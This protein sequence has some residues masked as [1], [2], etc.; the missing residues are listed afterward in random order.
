[1]CGTDVKLFSGAIPVALPRVL[2]HEI[3]GTVAV[4]GPRG[5]VAEGTRVLVDPSIA[6]GYCDLCRRD[7]S[8]LCRNGALMGRDLDG[9]FAELVAVDERQLHPIPETVSDDAAA[10]LQVLTTCVHA[11]TLVDVFPGMTAVVLGL[12]VSGQLH[13]QLLRARGLS[14]VI[15]VTRSEARRALAAELGATDVAA[16]EDAAALVA[17]RTG[18]RGADLVVESAGVAATLAQAVELAGLGG[19]VLAFGTI[20]A[21]TLPLP[22]Y[23]LYYKELRIVNARAARPRDCERAIQMAA[24]GA[25]RLEP[26]HTT[27]FELDAAAAA[28]E[29]C[30]SDPSALK[31]TMDVAA[32]GG[33]GGG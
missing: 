8:Y 25:L 19:T 22:S 1:V 4:A 11:Q 3:T 26:L 27:T 9:G 30:R 21:P 33:G 23:Q 16:P 15:G 24:S 2:G 20:T 12:G 13:A 7:L 17:E 18:G 6:C 10:L 14:C 28:L 31:V 5:L 32:G 29:A